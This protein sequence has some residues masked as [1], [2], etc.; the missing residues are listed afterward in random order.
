MR[1]DAKARNPIVVKTVAVEK[2]LDWRTRGSKFTNSI[3]LLIIFRSQMNYVK[4]DHTMSHK[5]LKY[6]KR[7]RLCILTFKLQISTSTRKPCV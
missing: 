4:N 1:N 6:N 7:N 5:L 3:Y 2:N